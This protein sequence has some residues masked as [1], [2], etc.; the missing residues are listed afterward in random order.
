MMLY[1]V[2]LRVRFTK[3]RLLLNHEYIYT[4]ISKVLIPH[5]CVHIA[6]NCQDKPAGP[7]F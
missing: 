4:I 3:A 2:S 5:V 6:A 1:N 7:Y